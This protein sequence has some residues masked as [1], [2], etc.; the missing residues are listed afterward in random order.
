MRKLDVT[1]PLEAQFQIFPLRHTSATEVETT[2]REYLCGVEPARAASGPTR[3]RLGRTRGVVIGDYR[4]NSLI[5]HASR[6]DLDE[7]DALDQEDRHAHQRARSMSCACFTLRNSLAEELAP[8]LQSAITGQHDP[9]RRSNRGS[10]G[11]Q[12][13]QFQQQQGS[14]N[15]G[16]RA[17]TGRQQSMPRRCCSS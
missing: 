12:F 13:Q 14:S 7:I 4:T 17:R 3:G 15:K 2:I 5:V 6:R 16:S 10:G 8:V 9:R 1:T 11:Q